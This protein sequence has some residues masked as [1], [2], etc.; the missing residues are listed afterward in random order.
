MKVRASSFLLA[1]L[2]VATGGLARASAQTVIV[3]G[4]PAG[5]TIEVTMNGGAAVSATADSLGDA[6]LAVPAAPAS[7]VVQIHL[8]MCGSA[9]RVLVVE[10]GVP[11]PTAGAGCQRIE[12]GSNFSMAAATTFVVDIE[13]SSASV[14]LRQGPPPREWLRGTGEGGRAARRQWGTPPKGLVLSAGAGLSKFGK[15]IDAACGDVTSCEKPSFSRSYSFAVDYW[16]TPFLAAEVSYIKPG[17]TTVTGS[18]TGFRF[19]SHLQTA[20]GTVVAKAGAP[21]GAVRPYGFGGLNRHQA[22]LTTNDTIDNTTVTVNGVTQTVVGGTQTFAQQT[23]G[24]NW[25]AGG[26][27]EAWATS[28]FAFYGELTI[29]KIKGA[30]ITGGEGGI[31]DRATSVMVG[32]RWHVGR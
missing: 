26:G 13:G 30:P 20:V 14:H 32:L 24:W 31:D 6:T 11:A 7:A 10:R 23:E 4:A 8:D 29:A 5:A 2:F 16:I 28:R 22:T 19:D 18:G 21:A 9:V 25:V 15:T 12:A 27:I 1:V 17:D 3:Q